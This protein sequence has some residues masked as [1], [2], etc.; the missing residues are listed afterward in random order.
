MSSSPIAS[1]LA[2]FA[3]EIVVGEEPIVVAG[4]DHGLER[5]RVDRDH[6]TA[7][8]GDVDVHPGVEEGVVR[9]GHLA[10]EHTGR[11][12]D[13]QHGRVGGDD[14]RP[15][16]RQLELD[17]VRDRRGASRP[18]AR[19][20][21]SRRAGGGGCLHGGPAVG[22]RGVRPWLVAVGHRASPARRPSGLTDA[23]T[24][25]RHGGRRPRLSA[26][27]GSA[28][29]SY[30]SHW[31]GSGSVR[32]SSPAGPSAARWRTPGSVQVRDRRTFRTSFQ[33]WSSPPSAS[34]TRATSAFEVGTD[35]SGH[36]DTQRSGWPIGT[37]HPPGDPRCT[38]VTFQHVVPGRSC[39]P[40]GPGRPRPDRRRSASGCDPAAGG[41]R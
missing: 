20:L 18:S 31:S 2:T 13:V 32:Y 38:R 8:A 14:Q 12:A 1:E 3:A 35:V 5:L 24:R 36:L 21:R 37:P 15:L 30:S 41:T 4:A 17:G 28:S 10:G 25:R 6:A 27:I 23:R 26:S 22:G 11:L 16:A 19:S 29:R 34:A 7:R 9:H 40:R 33:R 39:R